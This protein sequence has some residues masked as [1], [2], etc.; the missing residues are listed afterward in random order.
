MQKESIFKKIITWFKNIKTQEDNKIRN[1]VLD[2]YYQKE[3]G[4][5]K[6]FYP[7][8]DISL[9]AVERFTYL[10]EGIKIIFKFNLCFIFF[11]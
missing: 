8:E 11:C 4:S 10:P 5:K 1:K 7:K 9:E 2:E 6:I 3:Y